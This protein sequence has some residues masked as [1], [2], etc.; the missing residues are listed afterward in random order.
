MTYLTNE[1]NFVGYGWNFTDNH[2]ESSYKNERNINHLMAMYELP[3]IPRYH[4]QLYI[5]YFI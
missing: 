4:A 2:A 3:E 5:S 1:T